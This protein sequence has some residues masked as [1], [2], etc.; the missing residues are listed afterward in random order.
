M[1][2]N[3]FKKSSGVPNK[4]HVKTS[5][6]QPVRVWS[7]V[8]LK[9]FA[10]LFTGSVVNLSGWE[11][12]IGEI[13]S[14]SAHGDYEDMLQFLACQDP[15]GV[16]EIF[17]VH[18]EYDVQLGWQKRLRKAGFEASIPERHQEIGLRLD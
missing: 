2:L 16:K 11:D 3:L 13:R 7:N 1:K 17:L 9:K 4:D 15:R 5:K 10:H 6:A 12:E 8:E 18:G 14:M